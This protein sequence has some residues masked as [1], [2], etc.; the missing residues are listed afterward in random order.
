MWVG[1]E[2]FSP[3]LLLTVGFSSSLVQ[4]YLTHL[5]KRALKFPFIHIYLPLHPSYSMTTGAQ[6]GP[7]G[8]PAAVRGRVP[9]SPFFFWRGEGGG[10]GMWWGQ[11]RLTKSS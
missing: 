4:P 6:E 11:R 5:M 10:G 1:G 2:F 7:P 9:A 3:V 8:I